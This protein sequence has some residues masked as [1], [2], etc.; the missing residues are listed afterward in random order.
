M[1]SS[2]YIRKKFIEFFTHRS[3][4]LYPY[5]PIIDS[6]D[7]DTM[8]TIAGMKQ[9]TNVFL[10]H[11]QI[12][13]KNVI[14]IQPCLRMG[15]KHN[16][17]ANIGKTKRH[18]TFFEMLGNFSFGGY[19]KETAI[20][21]AF[22]FLT[23]LIDLNKMYFTVHPDDKESAMIWY[24]LVGKDKVIES[25]E[26]FWQAGDI[27]PCGYCTEIYV[28]PEIISKE[29][30]KRLIDSSSDHIKEVW[31]LVFMQYHQTFESRKELP[32]ILIDTGMGLERIVSVIDGTFD[33][34]ET[35]LLSP[36]VK[37]VSAKD[38]ASKRTA[39]DFLKST[40]FLLAEG[41]RPGQN[42]K[43]YIL[44]KLIRS[45][46]YLCKNPIQVVE[47]VQ[48]VMS[49][50]YPG[51]LTIDKSI[52]LEEIKQA[53]HNVFDLSSLRSIDESDAC[54]IYHTYGVPI[55]QI[56]Q[57]FPEL[58]NKR[59]SE[60]VQEHKFASQKKITV[61]WNNSTI[62][63]FYDHLE[64]ETIVEHIETCD[65]KFI[66]VT[67]ESC[68]YPRGGGQEG[69]R[70]EIIFNGEKI[71]VLDTLR[72]NLSDN[73]FVTMHI[74]E[75][76]PDDLLGKNVQLKVDLKFRL[77][78]T[79]A[80]SAVHLIGE[81]L[82]RKYGYKQNGSFVGEDYFRLDLAGEPISKEILQEAQDYA[83][84]AINLA[85][86][87]NEFICLANDVKD[88]ILM[89][90]HNYHSKVRVIEFSGY[91]KQLCGGTHVSNTKEIGEIK[92]I[93]ESSIGKGCRRI[94]GYTGDQTK[95]EEIQPKKRSSRFISQYT[96]NGCLIEV[97][98]NMTFKEAEKVLK[99]IPSNIKAVYFFN[100]EKTFL[101]CQNFYRQP[102][103]E[104]LGFKG[105][106]GQICML[107]NNQIIAF[108]R[109]KHIF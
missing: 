62:P 35:D 30:A 75:R 25:E 10:G 63:L 107:G 14:T 96:I 88:A 39:A 101:L 70:G 67:K 57:H 97:Y 18:N 31:N 53:N 24:S 64:N 54:K 40:V 82:M 11:E 95:K 56:L 33:N 26:N 94:E 23:D 65:E 19:A 45:A 59:L 109:I 92:I 1:K 5:C 37:V 50:A 106:F 66:V 74:C 20:S 49:D 34:F 22:D 12:Q 102:Q 44:R 86:P 41:L 27:G 68:F 84:S 21:Y 83:N 78:H 103:L 99:K 38:L 91:S 32:H 9:F 80:H 79:R 52:I 6:G 16:D 48:K 77:A 4:K 3:H 17:F 36:I 61:S 46:N 43:N 93:K 42:G 51:I 104:E 2:L 90:G 72:K 69:D 7:T 100:K 71:K 85:I 89:E 47:E 76:V 28:T 105:K 55:E 60:L 73:Y 81:I 15:G 29:N 13:D 58:D 8:F 108:E 87:K 98:E